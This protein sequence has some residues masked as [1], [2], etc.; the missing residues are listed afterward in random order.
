MP[1]AVRNVLNRDTLIPL[2]GVV[3]VILAVLA[4]GKTVLAYEV[5]RQVELRA[6]HSQ[7]A[8]MAQAMTGQWS[9]EQHEAWARELQSRNSHLGLSVPVQPAPW[10]MP[11]ER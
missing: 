3:A 11:R 7:L 8:T 1:P 10:D 4:I 6:I 9:R 2:G 5:Q